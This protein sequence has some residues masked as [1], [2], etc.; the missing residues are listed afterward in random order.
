MPLRLRNTAGDFLFEVAILCCSL[1]F[2]VFMS[3]IQVIFMN[4]EQEDTSYT[5]FTIYSTPEHGTYCCFQCPSA[6]VKKNTSVS[7]ECVDGGGRCF[8]FK[9]QGEILHKFILFSCCQWKQ[10]ILFKSVLVVGFGRSSSPKKMLL[11]DGE[12]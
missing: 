6:V 2:G 10:K 3:N 12:K 9:L 11:V 4:L 8:V 5:L 1:L 7:L